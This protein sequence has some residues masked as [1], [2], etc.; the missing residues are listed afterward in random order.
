MR[1]RINTNNDIEW[2]N[3]PFVRSIENWPPCIKIVIDSDGG[4]MIEYEKNS[5][6]NL[7]PGDLK[8]IE[9]EMGE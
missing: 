3:M 8:G 6:I 2:A 9:I 4:A 7:A 5:F 1:L